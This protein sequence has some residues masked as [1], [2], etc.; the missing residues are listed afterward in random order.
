MANGAL[1]L[2]FVVN[3][4]EKNAGVARKIGDTLKGI[5]AQ[6][7]VRMLRQTNQ[8]GSFGG[9]LAGAAIGGLV[10]K[11][12]FDF[13]KAGG[14]FTREMKFVEVSTGASASKLKEMRK[15]AFALAKEMPVSAME[16][17]QSLYTI[18]QAGFDASESLKLLKPIQTF[19]ALSHGE[20]DAAK[21]ASIMSATMR[22]WNMDASKATEITDVLASTVNA[23]RMDFKDLPLM[24]S[25]AARGVAAAGFSFKES[26][27]AMGLI[28]NI[29][30][31]A[32]RAAT[33]FGTFAERLNDTKARA[34]LLGQHI[35]VLDK[36]T[37]KKRD[38]SA[39]IGDLARVTS[40]MG[41]DQASQFM[42]SVF[43]ARASSGI[44]ALM[45][46]LRQGR[47]DDGQFRKGAELWQFM[48]DK[49][50]KGG[51][52]AKF[53]EAA[54]DNYAGATG[55]LG[56]A[57]DNLA[58]SFGES[59]G[60]IF[61]GPVDF[62]TKAV[63]GITD[64][65]ESLPGPIKSVASQILTIG[66]SV[67]FV[68]GTIKIMSLAWGLMKTVMGATS[69]MGMIFSPI[70]LGIGGVI[71]LLYAFKRSMDLNVGGAGMTMM[72]FMERVATVTDGVFQMVAAGR[73]TGD[74]AQK[75]I[76]DMAGGG[77]LLDTVLAIGG[78][79]E[80]VVNFFR[81]IGRGF[82]AIVQS[83]TA[84][85]ELGDSFHHLLEAMGLIAKHDP[86]NAADK[87]LKMGSAGETVGRILGKLADIIA[88]GL[89]VSFEV[90]A[91]IISQF[92]AYWPE[93]KGAFGGLSLAVGFFSEQVG[94]MLTVITGVP[95]DMNKATNGSRGFGE[96]LGGFLANAVII[97]TKLLG[98]FV[99][100][101]GMVVRGLSLVIGMVK[102]TGMGLSLFAQAIYDV[103]MTILDGIGLFFAKL[104][105]EVVVNIEKVKS[106]YHMIAFLKAD[107]LGDKE[108]AAKEAAAVIASQTK[109]YRQ[110]RHVKA[111]ALE[112][113]NA[114]DQRRLGMERTSEG[115]S[116]TWDAMFGGDANNPKKK[117]FYQAP[118]EMMP[119]YAQQ[120]QMNRSLSPTEWAAAVASQNKSAL[121]K[122]N[123]NVNLVAKAEM[124][125]QT[126]MTLHAKQSSIAGANDMSSPGGGENAY[127]D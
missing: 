20:L 113:S 6:D 46:Q 50:G 55:R 19:T 118:V 3:W 51:T 96:D 62:M 123:V 12:S 99:A 124:D 40:A 16:S 44:N 116:K 30:P 106:A 33:A 35:D 53:L 101:L 67:L 79:I 114:G 104:I 117:G 24:L 59:F 58:V 95:A 70:V 21:S 80:R 121:E 37:G 64:F 13:A 57:W 92:R 2:G 1:N 14:D 29:I 127:T 81:G 102:I 66:S 22:I 87:W 52:A 78:A 89:S 45:L 71:A 49:I 39:I 112:Q 100:V 38:A 91:G 68:A 73:I 69:L 34:L 28:R 120:A 36:K 60:E 90:F 11:K 63:I 5:Q 94:G 119:A 18:G 105:S 42:Q 54:T 103:F 125:G 56:K 122:V 43:K 115:I 4:T 10:L 111:I 8:M 48:A 25:G 7:Q 126:L 27:T 84:F 97:T 108:G 26:M 41:E 17:A 31:T 74:T 86:E 75:L 107:M 15:E 72:H 23:T 110:E 98:G 85:R 82:D 76:D 47:T 88:T 83:S 9:A 65:W 93:L 109:I 32:E 61:K 77:G